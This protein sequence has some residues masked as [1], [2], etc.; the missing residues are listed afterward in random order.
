M[1]TT[2]PETMSQPMDRNDINARN[3]NGETVSAPVDNATYNL[4]MALTSKLESIEVYSK[5]AKDGDGD[6]WVRL[7]ADDRR[8]AD[9][10]LATLKQRLAGS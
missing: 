6:L 8:H 10:L 2:T 7:G 5:Y 4:L 9:E 3:G 1:Q